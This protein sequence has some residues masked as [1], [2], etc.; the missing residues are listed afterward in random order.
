[1][2]TLGIVSDTHVNLGGKRQLAPQLFEVLQGVDLILHAGDLNTLRVVTD[3][4][5]LAP[6]YAVHGNN[7]DWEAAQ[8]PRTRIIEVEGCRI[9]LAHGDMGV[10]EDLVL[11]KGVGGAL[12]SWSAAAALS[13][14]EDA[15]ID[16]L[17]FGHSHWPLIHPHIRPSDGRSILLFNP[18]SAG[19]KRKAPHHSC[20]LLRINGTQ[21]DAKLVTW[22]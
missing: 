17:V 14:F 18:G 12:S 11:F 16:C 10:R 2:T 4:E 7:E 3:L 15:P 1:M 19:K 13:H 8:L 5:A 6:V 22:D 21:L 20:G 9:G